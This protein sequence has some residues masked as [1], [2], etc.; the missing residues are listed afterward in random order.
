M[1]DLPKIPE[2]KEIMSGLRYEH[3][4][5]GASG[6]ER[7]VFVFFLRGSN[8]VLRTDRVQTRDSSDDRWRDV[9]VWSRFSES[10]QMER[11]P[12][13]ESVREAALHHFRSKITF[14]ED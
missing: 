5:A 11:Q 3:F 13:P 14:C 6:L 1:I 4:L 2:T 10:N 7:R 8:V 12:V 9:Q